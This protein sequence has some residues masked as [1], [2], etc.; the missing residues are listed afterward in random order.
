[1]EANC[2]PFLAQSACGHRRCHVFPELAKF[3]PTM[4]RRQIHGHGGGA[5]IEVNG[6][7]NK[8]Q[9]VC[10]L[11]PAALK[12]VSKLQESMGNFQAHT[13]SPRP[14]GIKQT[15]IP[16]AMEAPFPQ[17]SPL[18]RGTFRLARVRKNYE[19]LIYYSSKP[20]Q[21]KGKLHLDLT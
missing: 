16:S 20:F 3:L 17:L 11:S 21:K 12:V 1:M 15:P 9:H 13:K 19:A 5:N 8:P 4:F 7:S 14:C 6:H 18:L 10:H 2:K